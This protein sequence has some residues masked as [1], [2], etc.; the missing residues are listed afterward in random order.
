METNRNDY[1]VCSMRSTLRTPW[2]HICAFNSQIFVNNQ[3]FF[4]FI[5]RMIERL[6][7]IFSRNRIN[8]EL[9]SP[10][11]I[12]N[13]TEHMKSYTG[14]DVNSII[15]CHVMLCWSSAMSC[16]REWFN[17]PEPWL[18]D[19]YIDCILGN[20]MSNKMFVIL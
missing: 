5:I 7:Q 11:S 14:I 18:P 9:V 1:N 19:V 8:G 20:R 2:I 17:I 16:S 6:M 3:F 10:L 4:S 12:L 15:L 13:D